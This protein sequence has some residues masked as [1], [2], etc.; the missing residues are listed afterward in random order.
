[1]LQVGA[2]CSPIGDANSVPPTALASHIM[3]LLRRAYWPA[4]S[5]AANLVSFTAVHGKL[6]SSAGTG[7]QDGIASCRVKVQRHNTSHVK[8]ALGRGLC[9]SRESR[10]EIKENILSQKPSRR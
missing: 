9:D 8:R 3:I 5:A 10:E 1:V 2:N 6:R 4:R 7:L